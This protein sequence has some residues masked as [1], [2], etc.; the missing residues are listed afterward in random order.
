[1]NK[2]VLAVA[3]ALLV[4]ASASMFADNIGCGLGAFCSRA[5]RAKVGKSWEQP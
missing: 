4:G 2:K 5:N 3:T 1:M